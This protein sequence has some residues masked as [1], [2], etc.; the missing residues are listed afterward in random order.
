MNK[1]SI[2]SKSRQHNINRRVFLKGAGSLGVAVSAATL[3]SE[4]LAAGYPDIANAT[5]DCGFSALASD[6]VYLNSGTEGSMPSCVLEALKS[7]LA[8]WASNP[9]YSY[10]TD[11]ALGKHQHQNREKV[12]GFL[13][14]EKNNICLTDNMT[15]GT[16]IHHIKSKM[17]N[18]Y[19]DIKK[20]PAPIDQ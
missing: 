3:S 10:E 8:Q 13:S 9:T 1:L 16:P 15:N 6:F 7:N 11:A 20:R 12:A 19:P 5:R 4:L 18:V 14:V 17:N 2:D